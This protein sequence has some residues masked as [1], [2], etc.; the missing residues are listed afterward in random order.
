MTSE[1]KDK[2]A[3]VTG[4]RAA[5][6][7]ASR[8]LCWR[9][10]REGVDLRARRECSA[11][12]I[13]KLRGTAPCGRVD[14]SAADVRNYENC[15]KLVRAGPERFRR[16]ALAASTRA[17]SFSAMRGSIATIGGM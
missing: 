2:V 10:R 16:E 7:S 4:G 11:S 8:R 13:D 6:A 12:G 5:S 17:G 3:V 15:R 9:G 14:G 1:L